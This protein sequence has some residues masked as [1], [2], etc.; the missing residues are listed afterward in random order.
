MLGAASS[1]PQQLAW[2]M[3]SVEEGTKRAGSSQVSATL[4]GAVS[5]PWHAS[6]AD[7]DQRA[8]ACSS[9]SG[10]SMGN[11]GHCMQPDRHWSAGHG[12]QL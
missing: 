3:D 4:M 9:A 1:E 10:W 11:A 12:M 7:D 6:L 5:G 8:M 2:R